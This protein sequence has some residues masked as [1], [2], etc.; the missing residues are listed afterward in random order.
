[1]KKDP[2]RPLKNQ[3]WHLLNRLGWG[4]MLQLHLT[5]ALRE[6]GWFQTFHT[7]ASVDRQGRPIPWY[8]Y[9]CIDFLKTRL[10]ANMQVFE[11][12]S[13]HSTRWLAQY[14]GRVLAV[15]HEPAWI[16]KIRPQL[17]PNAQVLFEATREGENGPYA[18]KPQSLHQAFDLIV[19]DGLDR[20]HCLLQC[21]SALSA[22]GVIL[23]DDASRPEYQAG[24]D[25][26]KAQGFKELPFF[27]IKPIVAYKACT[28]IFYR[29]GNVLGI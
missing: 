12:G 16:A 7:K 15:E 25:F 2:L 26:L 24:I 4:G 20:V 8:T 29:E 22:S 6:D 5:G 9:P 21:P 19:V 18:H 10:N 17:P 13:G 23:L 11:Y 27:G 28:S 14:T 1:M 3:V